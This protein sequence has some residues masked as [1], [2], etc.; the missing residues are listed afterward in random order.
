MAKGKGR[1][2]GKGKG[3]KKPAKKHAKKHKPAH[4]GGARRGGGGKK[5]SASNV[6]RV[7]LKIA[8]RKIQARNGTTGK[9]PTA[10]EQ[11]IAS[12]TVARN[13]AGNASYSHGRALMGS[14]GN[15]GWAEI[16]QQAMIDKL[17]GYKR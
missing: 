6:D 5:Y 13:K 7:L 10:L 9:P 3:G 16:A 4:R 2:G 1:H 17:T 14:A 12:M 15:S 11:R 8:L